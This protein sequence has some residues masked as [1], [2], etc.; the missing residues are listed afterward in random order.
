MKSEKIFGTTEGKGKQFYGENDLLTN[1]A[2][3]IWYVFQIFHFF[4]GPKVIFDNFKAES[5]NF[6]K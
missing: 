1:L 6:R 3:V 4:R 5:P 2:K